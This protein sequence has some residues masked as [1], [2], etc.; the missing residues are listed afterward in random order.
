M[1]FNPKEKLRRV[2]ISE[3]LQRFHEE[4][5]KYE[6]SSKVVHNILVVLMLIAL[7]FTLY[8][9]EIMTFLPF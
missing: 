9:E 6:K 8:G 5:R 3:G 7:A 1:R 4:R 2:K